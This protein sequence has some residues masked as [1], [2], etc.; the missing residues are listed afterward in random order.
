MNDSFAATPE[1][2]EASIDAAIHFITLCE[3]RARIAKPNNIA[4]VRKE[5]AAF[6]SGPLQ[7]L[8]RALLEDYSDGEN[9]YQPEN[10]DFRLS[11]AKEELCDS[12]K[13]SDNLHYLTLTDPHQ[14]SKICAAIINSVKESYK[15]RV[16][17]YQHT[18]TETDFPVEHSSDEKK[19]VALIAKKKEAFER[20]EKT[21]KESI[22]KTLNLA[23]ESL[24]S[25]VTG[26]LARNMVHAYTGNKKIEK[27]LD[28]ATRFKEAMQLFRL[29]IPGIP[30][31]AD[32]L[33]ELSSEDM[34]I[35]PELIFN[36]IMIDVVCTE[37]YLAQLQNKPAYLTQNDRER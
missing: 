17:E 20:V 3:E 2:S 34:P 37:G 21:L 30:N 32:L 5:K 19:V 15:D 14:F 8:G 1:F 28:E 4:V 31:T 18:F 24:E 13:N 36:K 10:I 29:H 27:E 33:A 35:T 7:S 16:F 9:I 26:I 22:R 25:A 11:I 6:L 12:L 23:P